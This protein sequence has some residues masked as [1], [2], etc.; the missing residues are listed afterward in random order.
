MFRYIGLYANTD[1]K[2]VTKG[3]EWK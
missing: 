3:M 1:I 2:N